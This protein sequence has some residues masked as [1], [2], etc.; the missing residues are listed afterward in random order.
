M[1]FYQI[2]FIK[3]RFWNHFYQTFHHMMGRPAVFVAYNSIGSG[4]GKDSRELCYLTG[5]GHTVQVRPY[6]LKTVQN[7]RTG[8]IKGNP[9]VRRDGNR[10]GCTRHER[11]LDSLYIHF[12]FGLPVFH[13]FPNPG[14][15]EWSIS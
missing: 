7:I 6:H 5:Y 13:Y 1:S 2:T 15:T 12:V 9:G 3:L 11:E 10:T 8:N 14:I 4:L